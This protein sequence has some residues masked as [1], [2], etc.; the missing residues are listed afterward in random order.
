MAGRGQCEH[1][2]RPRWDSKVAPTTRRGR[3]DARSTKP[4]EPFNRRGSPLSGTLL[5]AQSSARGRMS[6]R[7]ER[8]E[9][10]RRN[11][12]QLNVPLGEW[13]QSR[14]GNE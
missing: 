12:Q 2:G 3:G 10:V 9:G 4:L 13:A 8:H 1:L 7:M 5:S 14:A 11:R 6:T